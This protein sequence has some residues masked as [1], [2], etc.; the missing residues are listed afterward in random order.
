MAHEESDEL[1]VDIGKRL[2]NAVASYPTLETVCGSQGRSVQTV[3][4][5]VRRGQRADAPEIYRRFAAAFIKADAE[6]AG[7]CYRRFLEMLEDKWASRAAKILLEM[8]DRRWKLGEGSDVMAVVKQGAKRTDDLE[9]MLSAPSP[10]VRALLNKCGWTRSADWQ[11][12]V[13]ML[14]A[15]SEEEP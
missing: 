4:N 14:P 12:T 11:P 15:P 9:A 1:T 10:R 3:M 6:F 7:I 5:W 2:I 8:M 13:K